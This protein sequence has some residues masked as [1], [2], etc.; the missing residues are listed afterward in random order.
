MASRSSLHLDIDKNSR[1]IVGMEQDK[2]I[3]KDPWWIHQMKI[4]MVTL[5]IIAI[6]VLGGLLYQL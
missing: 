5:T 3:E 1:M 4:A 2:S 6:T